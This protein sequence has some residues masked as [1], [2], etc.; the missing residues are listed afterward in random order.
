[1][2]RSFI[3]LKPETL[4]R[5]LVGQVLSRFENKGLNIVELKLTRIAETTAREH[6]KHHRDKS[7]FPGLI[8]SITA[9]PVV[10]AI[11]EGPEAVKVVRNLVG[12]T[13]PA[14]APPGTIRGDFGTELPANIV[15]AADSP[16]TATEEIERFFK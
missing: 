4:E 10:M 7:F 8:K 15:H 5:G 9:G 6:Y 3:I 12:A 13:N 2:E 11:I 14:E 16:E 1:M